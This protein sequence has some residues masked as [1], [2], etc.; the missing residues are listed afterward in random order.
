MDRLGQ[1]KSAPSKRGPPPRLD[2]KVEQHL[3]DWILY[4]HQGGFP[5][6]NARLTSE[7]KSLAFTAGGAAARDSV[8][9]KTWRKAFMKRHPDLKV[10]NS[11]LIERCCKMGM[12]KESIKCYF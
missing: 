2:D 9:G 10:M 3:M 12:T 4:V 11:S 6:T 1:R 7:V 5:V 8:G